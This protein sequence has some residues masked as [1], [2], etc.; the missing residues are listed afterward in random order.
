MVAVRSVFMGTHQG[1]FAGIP[2]TGRSV[3]AGVMLFYRITDGKIDAFWMQ[4]DVPALMAQL[5][6]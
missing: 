5:T 2:P 1:E 6:A 3:Q 4:L